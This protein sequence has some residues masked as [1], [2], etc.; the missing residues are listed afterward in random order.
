ME[1]PGVAPACRGGEV[2]SVRQRR[3]V[4]LYAAQMSA[5]AQSLR[6]PAPEESSV[7]AW[8]RRVP[9]PTRNLSPHTVLRRLVDVPD[10]W[11]RRPREAFAA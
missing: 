7:P 3:A 8:L 4:A 6:F 11:R 10:P 9:S 2:Q 5:T 1:S